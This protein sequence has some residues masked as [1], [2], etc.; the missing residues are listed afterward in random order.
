VRGWAFGMKDGMAG[1]QRERQVGYCLTLRPLFFF[2]LLRARHSERSG[3]IFSYP[4]LLRGVGPCREESLFG[5][6]GR[7]EA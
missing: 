5:S 7:G 2:A 4:L 6:W 1:W 3:P